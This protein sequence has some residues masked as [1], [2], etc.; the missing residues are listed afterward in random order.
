MELPI[1]PAVVTGVLRHIAF[2]HDNGMMGSGNVTRK[3]ARIKTQHSVR[4]KIETSIKSGCRVLI[5]SRKLRGLKRG[6][7]SGEG[8][9]FEGRTTC[10]LCNPHA[11][12][13]DF[14][15]ILSCILETSMTGGTTEGVLLLT[16]CVGCYGPTRSE[17][18]LI[19]KLRHLAI[20]RFISYEKS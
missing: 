20:S 17:S 6:P 10:E 19:V 4:I 16:A 3:G 13:H 11:L 12:E 8:P 7:T 5:L 14:Q 9:R 2:R 15:H 18:P 1:C